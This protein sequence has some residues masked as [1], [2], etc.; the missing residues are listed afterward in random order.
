MK[1]RTPPRRTAFAAAGAVALMLALAGCGNDSE[2][3]AGSSEDPSAAL[4]AA[5][6]NFDE[7]SSV[8]FT[9][10]TKSKPTKGDAVL[11]AEGT[12]TH[13]PAFEGS[14]KALYLGITADIPLIAVDGKVFANIP[15]S[16]GFEEINPAEYSAPDPATFADPEVGISGLLTKLEDVENTGEKRQGRLV[17]TTYA[18]TLPG[19]L[20]APIIPSADDAGTYRTVV[21]ID[22]DGRIATL[23]VTGDFFEGSGEV[24]YD[25]AFDEY[26]KS[27][28]ISAP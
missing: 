27:V 12:L 26:D 23:Q 15:F 1:L 11:G 10:A 18:G 7:A 5:K 14:V 13:Q 22:E 8:H 4:A 28:T 16:G 21:G 6:K 17:V 19:S 3:D 2:K 25:L 24:T 9:M 20:V